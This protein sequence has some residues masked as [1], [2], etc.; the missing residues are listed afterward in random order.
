[1]KMSDILEQIATM[2]TDQ[3][4]EVAEM[5]TIR[6]DHIRD[7]LKVGFKV[8][9]IVT[10][11]VPRGKNR[12][13][14]IGEIIKKNPKKLKVAAHVEGGYDLFRTTWNVPYSMVEHYNDSDSKTYP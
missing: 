1:M 2:D 3:L 12:G 4:N 13:K 10:F 8:H 11:T 5:L 14:W 6:R 7:N 9:D